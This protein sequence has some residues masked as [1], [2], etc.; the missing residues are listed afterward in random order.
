MPNGEVIKTFK[1]IHAGRPLISVT[2][3]LKSYGNPIQ[4]KGFTLMELM[5]VM[6]VLAILVSMVVPQYLDRVADARETL[7]KHNLLGLRTSIDQFYRDKT[8][9]PRTLEELVTERYIRDVPMDPIAQRTNTWV[10]VPLSNGSDQAVFNVKSGAK[11]LAK[12]G[13]DYASW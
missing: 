9:Y 4:I 3:F 10:I 11:G 2:R 5:V 8:R 6:A 7:L 12:D 13:T 1:T